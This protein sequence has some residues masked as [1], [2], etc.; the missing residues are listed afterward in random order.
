M[1]KTTKKTMKKQTVAKRY[2]AT[3]AEVGDEDDNEVTPLGVF[4]TRAAA[5]RAIEKHIAEYFDEWVDCSCGE[6]YREDDEDEI[7]VNSGDGR[8]VCKYNIKACRAK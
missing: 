8:Y 4:S 3:C 1:K 6:A 7:T 5:K 2:V